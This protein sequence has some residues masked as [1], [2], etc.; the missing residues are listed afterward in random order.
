MKVLVDIC[1]GW[2]VCLRGS[3]WDSASPYAVIELSFD[4]LGIDP[5]LYLLARARLPPPPQL[6]PYE[7]LHI[8]LCL[9]FC[10]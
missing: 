9:Y 3:D 8:S 1:M 6:E 10:Y 2:H 7:Y 4:S 5:P